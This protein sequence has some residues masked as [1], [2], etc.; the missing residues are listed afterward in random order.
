MFPKN[1]FD[2]RSEEIISPEEDNKIIVKIGTTASSRNAFSKVLTGES[3]S[4]SV[5][6][7]LFDKNKIEYIRPLFE[8]EDNME[9]IEMNMPN[10]TR[11]IAMLRDYE[12]PAL[13]GLNV[14]K[15]NTAQDAAEAVVALSKEPFIEYA[16]I[17]AV[18]KIAKITDP[19]QNRQWGLRAINYFGAINMPGFNNGK[20][21]KIAILDSGIDPNHPDLQ[22]ISIV[23][24]NFSTLPGND[25]LGHG[26][27]VAGIIAAVTN[28]GIG[29]SGTCE[30][31]QLMILRGL[32][33]PYDSTAY[34]NAIKYASDNGAQVLN[35]SLGGAYD[36]TEALL[37]KSAIS[38]GMIVVA[39]MGNH[40]KFGNP[41]S[42]PAALPDV[43]AIGASTEI[44][45]RADFSQTGNHI[46]IVAPGTNI[47]STV[48]TYK[49]AL[50]E[51][52]N[53][54]AWDGT[55]MATPFVSAAIALLLA[56]N[57]NAS[58]TDIRTA[59]QKS[60]VKIDGQTGFTDEL[61]HGL[62]NLSG[63]LAIV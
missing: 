46:C 50:A 35:C 45:R 48:P 40:F 54:I 2:S 58:L 16:H 5:L 61:G 11:S 63:A 52:L 41:T 32:T 31:T 1:N 17:P 38:K 34:Y 20:N 26:T 47:L 7:N 18:R 15:F 60:A 36:P 9:K 14:L 12:D 6:F 22:N 4:K 25:D 39:A 55:S 43:L 10:A 23:N 3:K 49:V 30:S 57:P 29:I 44:N 59:L 27:H 33:S 37:V 42:Y 53:Y 28:N 56:K 51:S 24:K 62:L 8:G 19:E 21:V 13:S